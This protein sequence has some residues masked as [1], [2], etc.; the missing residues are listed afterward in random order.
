MMEYI[1]K[2]VVCAKVN[3]LLKGYSENVEKFRGGVTLW[4]NRLKRVLACLDSILAKLADNQLTPDE[5]KESATE[6]TA[7]IKEW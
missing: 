1:I 4:V 3:A 6:I 2:R 7:L 5:V